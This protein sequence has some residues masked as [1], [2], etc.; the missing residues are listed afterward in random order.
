MNVWVAGR[1]GAILK[2][3][4]PIATVK[5]P[6]PKLPPV[7]RGGPPKLRPITGQN[8][9]ADDGDIPPALPPGKKPAHPE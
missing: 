3:N 9:I 7:L 5:V 6:T 1:G 8:I 4:E 2:R